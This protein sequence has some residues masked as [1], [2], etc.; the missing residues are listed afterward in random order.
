S[1]PAEEER[2]ILYVAMTRARQG[3]Y[4]SWARSRSFRGRT[5]SGGPS[6]FLGELEGLV[7]L[8]AEGRRIKRDP[9]FRLF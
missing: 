5:L 4:L 8:A 1:F 3:L 9:Q 2:R 7:P 6:R